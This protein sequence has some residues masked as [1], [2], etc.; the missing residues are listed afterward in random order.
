MALPLKSL[1]TLQI[2]T[3]TKLGLIILVSLVFI[4][5]AFAIVRV[6]ESSAS[7]EHVNPIWLALWSI[8]EAGV[9]E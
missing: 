9:G 1:W 2:N 4:I 6:V 5:M 8:V 3:R 7:A